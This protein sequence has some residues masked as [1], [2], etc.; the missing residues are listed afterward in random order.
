MGSE[1]TGCDRDMRSFD[2]VD[3]K[4]GFQ[5]L[6]SNRSSVQVSYVSQ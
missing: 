5:M 4:C 2:L 1:I 3:V 6:I